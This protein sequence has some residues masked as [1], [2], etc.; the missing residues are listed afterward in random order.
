LEEGKTKLGYCSHVVG[1]FLSKEAGNRARRL[2]RP[3]TFA[4]VLH[5][6]PLC[7]STA[8]QC[9]SSSGRTVLRRKIS[10]NLAPSLVAK[11]WRH[12]VWRPTTWWV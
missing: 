6:C 10:Q 3:T 1:E 8:G 11:A 5:S 7:W 4:A 9:W 2:T 12:R